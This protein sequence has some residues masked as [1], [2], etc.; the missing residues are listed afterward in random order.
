MAIYAISF[1]IG[2]EGDHQARSASLKQ[3]IQTEAVDF[4]WTGTEC[5]YVIESPKNTEDLAYFLYR[6]TDLSSQHDE[7]LVINLTAKQHVAHGAVTERK[8][9][10]SLLDRG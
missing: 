3:K 2:P 4:A 9:L 10:R 5:F 6:S 1:R 7:L 8:V